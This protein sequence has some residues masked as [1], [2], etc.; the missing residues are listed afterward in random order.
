MV[1]ENKTST[2]PAPTSDATTDNEGQ[3]DK[4]ALRG[5]SFAE[6]EAALKPGD[7]APKPPPDKLAGC[8][9]SKAHLEFDYTPTKWDAAGKPT[10]YRQNQRYYHVPAGKGAGRD[11]MNADGNAGQGKL[12]SAHEYHLMEVNGTLWWEYT[13]EN[14]V[15]T[16]TPISTSGRSAFDQMIDCPAAKGSFSVVY[17][18]MQDGDKIDVASDTGKP[19]WSTGTKVATTPLGGDAL[20]KAGVVTSPAVDFDCPTKQLHVT[21]DPMNVNSDWELKLI[22]RTRGD[23]YS[24]D[25]RYGPIGPDGRDLA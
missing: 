9:T 7:D 19:L 15:V 18:T 8:D 12:I 24:S 20:G 23:S 11:R 4:S 3:S 10:Q 21:V 17:N 5:K 16:E 13:R 2:T 1:R 6:G 25:G 14:T 22:F